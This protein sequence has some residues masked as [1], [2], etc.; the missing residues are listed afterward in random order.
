MICFEHVSFGYAFLE[1]HRITYHSWNLSEC[2][3]YA[4]NFD[5]V[6][7]QWT[8]PITIRYVDTSNYTEDFGR[9]IGFGTISS[10]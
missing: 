2:L 8:L 4:V 1:Q 7:V 3:V 10:T 9:S 5:D 6:L